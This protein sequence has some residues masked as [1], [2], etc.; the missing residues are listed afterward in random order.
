MYQQTPARAAVSRSQLERN[1][2]HLGIRTPDTVMVHASL[3]AIGPIEG[4]AEALVE[5][6]LG[7]L[8][9]DGTLM[10]YVDYERV[11]ECPYFDPAR[12]PA[13]KEYGVFPEVVRSWP[14]AVRSNNPGASVCAIGRRA[15]FLCSGHPLDFGYGEGS[16]LAKLVESDGKILLLG[17]HFDHVTSLHYA[18]HIAD[19]P[20]KRIIHRPEKILKDGTIVDLV[21]EE[22]DTSK[23]V[24]S[25]MPDD[26]FHHLIEEFVQDSSVMHGMVGY[27]KSYVLPA[28]Q[29]IQFAVEKMQREYGT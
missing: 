24:I 3:R 16:P 18:E 2:A 14:G 10:A 17:S 5:A 11:P 6:I 20:G 26:Y 8:Q 25:S 9:P 12:S 19:L 4:R 23:P 21:I 28:K 29:L 22:F 7:A 15:E 13:P 27:A 1:L